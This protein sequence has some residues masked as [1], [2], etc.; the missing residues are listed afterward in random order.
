MVTQT[1]NQNET[2]KHI[3]NINNPI[4]INDLDVI[5]KGNKLNPIK[6]TIISELHSEPRI[7][8]HPIIK[9]KPKIQKKQDTEKDIKGDNSGID[10]V[11]ESRPTV[12]KEENK[13]SKYN[14]NNYLA[15]YNRMKTGTDPLQLPKKTATQL[16]I[17]RLLDNMTC[18]MCKV[19]M[20]KD[21]GIYI[22]KGCAIELNST[23]SGEAEW[24]N[25]DDQVDSSRCNNVTNMLLYESSFSTNIQLNYRSSLSMKKLGVLQTWLNMSPKE[26]S[27][28]EV[29]DTISYYCS[30]KLPQSIIQLSHMLYKKVVEKQQNHGKNT[31]SRGDIRDGLICACVYYSCYLHNVNRSHREIG[32]MLDVDESDVT[33]GCKLF[34][35]LMNGE[36]DLANNV[37][38]YNDFV[39]RFCS[40]LGL[41]D[42]IKKK[43]HEIAKK[44]TEM[45]ILDDK[46]PVSIASGVIYF[47]SNIY[48]LNLSKNIIAQQC[49]S[50]TAT[51]TKTYNTLIDNM[52]SLL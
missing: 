43:V 36:Y 1:Q 34:F 52:E 6:P 45:S 32:E 41:D 38:T 11:I 46:S 17:E 24:N 21:S 49:G 42:D 7:P 33:R 26:R 19:D 50:S 35:K 2:T 9:I 27:L 13:G 44:A 51:I 12:A 47:I 31:L 23:I 48:C 29:F 28:K 5:T 8:T 20:I 4:N 10:N 15:I 39:D 25:Y 18:P 22:C 3:E 14:I 40:H 16:S 37:L 30:T